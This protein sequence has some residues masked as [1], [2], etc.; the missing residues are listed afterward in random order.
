MSPTSSVAQN[1]QPPADFWSTAKPYAVSSFAAGVAI[2]PSYRD[3]VVKSALQ[4][5]VSAEAMTGL[6]KLTGGMKLSPSVATVVG[7]QMVLQEKVE[8]L[9]KTHR[10][11]DDSSLSLKF[12]SS[13]VVGFISSPFVAVFNGKAASVGMINTL[14]TFSPKQCLVITAQETAF[15]GG[16]S[17]ADKLAS[18][19]KERFGDNKAVDYTAAGLTGGLG[20]LAGHPFNTAVTRSQNKLPMDGFNQ[21][22]FNGC[23]QSMQGSL[24]KARAIAIFAVAYKFTKEMLNPPKKAE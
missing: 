9:M 20:S 23:K 15:V 19:L 1:K 13:G 4:Q 21:S 3:L 24:T 16:L 10:R 11:E 18:I 8:N 5:G 2:V 14:R 6:T 12:A 7:T 17:V 22:F